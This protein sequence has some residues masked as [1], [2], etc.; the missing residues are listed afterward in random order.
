MNHSSIQRSILVYQKVSTRHRSHQRGSKAT[1]REINMRF[2]SLNK[3]INAYKEVIMELRKEVISIAKEYNKIMFRRII[4]VFGIPYDFDKYADIIKKSKEVTDSVD[5]FQLNHD[6][7]HREIDLLEKVVLNNSQKPL[8]Y[9][10]DTIAEYR[11][12]SK[13]LFYVI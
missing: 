3:K 5:E 10:L 2:E 13:F 7:I 4:S 9:G 1:V 6:R 8:K 11:K 12:K